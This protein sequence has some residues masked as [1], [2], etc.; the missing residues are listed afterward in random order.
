MALRKV[1]GNNFRIYRGTATFP[2]ETSCSVN[3]QGNMEEGSTKDSAGAWQ[4]QDMTEKQWNVQ[5]EQ[6]D[7][8]L[9]SL[10]SLIGLFV[11]DTLTQ[12]GWDESDAAN[13]SQVLNAEFAR[14]GYAYMNDLV[15]QANDR[16][17]S[18]VTTQWQGYGALA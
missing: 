1:K 4:V 17:D 16:E 15:I 14:G 11:N 2:L 5:V 12:I 8:E 13:P 7:A 10:R 9:A 18:V 6:K 3:I